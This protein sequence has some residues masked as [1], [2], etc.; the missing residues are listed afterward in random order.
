MRSMGVFYVL[1]CFCWF[2][3]YKD[4]IRKL[5]WGKLT[6][7]ITTFGLCF[8]CAQIP[9]SDRHEDP[10]WKLNPHQH[11]GFER[12]AVIPNIQL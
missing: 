9:E 12:V 4:T 2:L 8:P 10:H 1:V 6:P 7:V 5:F 11:S 3:Q